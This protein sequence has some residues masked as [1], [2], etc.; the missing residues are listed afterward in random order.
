M[1]SKQLHQQFCKNSAYNY[2]NF[3]VNLDYIKIKSMSAL[4]IQNRKIQFIQSFL[5]VN[6][7]DII[8]KF[9]ELLSKAREKQLKQYVSAPLTK[10]ALNKLI[11][12]AEQDKLKGKLTKAEDLLKGIEKW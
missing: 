2:D 1:V 10:K 4:T 3:F 11:D 12:K 5:K 6:D 8:S 9:E 7:D